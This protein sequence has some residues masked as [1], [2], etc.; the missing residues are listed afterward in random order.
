MGYPHNWHMIRSL[1]ERFMDDVHRC[2][3]YSLSRTSAKLFDTPQ[4]FGPMVFEAFPSAASDIEEAAKC[5]A[6]RR[7]TAAVFH[8]MRVMEVGLRTTANALGVKYAP[9][10]ESYLR[11]MKPLIEADWSKKPAKWKKE[12]E[13]F[14]DV[15]TYLH[16]V[17]R[18]WR[19]PVMHVRESYTPE[20]AKEIFGAVK[21]FMLHLATKVSEKT[22]PRKESLVP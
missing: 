20:V 21:S 9:S 14:K 11:Q 7:G 15:Y 12:E 18:A 2:Y 6:L 16:G 3:L 13:F 1:Q 22:K 4:S 8:L 10:W 17:K 5:L 19:N